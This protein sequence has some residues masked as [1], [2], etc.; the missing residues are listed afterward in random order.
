V[1]AQA[2]GTKGSKNSY[3]AGNGLVGV[4][5]NS[6]L[7]AGMKASTMTVAMQQESVLFDEQP[8]SE[9][10]ADA[11]LTALKRP[12]HIPKDR[13]S[14]FGVNFLGIGV[15]TSAGEIVSVKSKDVGVEEFGFLDT[16]RSSIGLPKPVF[17]K[18]REF[19]HDFNACCMPA[20]YRLTFTFETKTGGEH[21]ASMPLTHPCSDS[22]CGR[23][24]DYYQ[25]NQYWDPGFPFLAYQIVQFDYKRNSA[26][27]G[28]AVVTWDKV[29]SDSMEGCTSH[30][31]I[32]AMNLGV[33]IAV[34]FAHRMD[35]Q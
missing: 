2:T 3:A 17:E 27:L 1:L 5:L 34:L 15:E 32:A 35:T 30:G 8:P 12:E 14:M 20:D 26:S 7:I 6:T 19:T 10:F 28:Q 9:W 4:D 16:G 31:V 33:V 18:V 25:P 22:P 24:L 11:N 29:T 13:Y 21:K 23:C